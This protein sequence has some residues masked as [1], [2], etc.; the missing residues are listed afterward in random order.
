M[1]RSV[2]ERERS[3]SGAPPFTGMHVDAPS[4]ELSA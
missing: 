4:L 2:Q 1:C 3:D